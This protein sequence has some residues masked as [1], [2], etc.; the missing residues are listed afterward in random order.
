M[1]EGT[2]EVASKPEHAV[3]LSEGL[4]GNNQRAPSIVLEG[5]GV[6]SFRMA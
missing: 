3:A 2:L 5:K 1:N 6:A 4:A